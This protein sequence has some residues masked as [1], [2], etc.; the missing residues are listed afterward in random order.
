MAKYETS[1]KSRLVQE[2]LS[3]HAGYRALSARYGVS[4]TVLKS[5]VTRFKIHGEAGLSKK[6]EHYSAGFKESVLLRMHSSALSCTEVAALY[7]I[8]SGG[9]IV[10]IW[11]RLYHEGGL[12]ALHPKPRGRRPMTNPPK[13]TPSVAIAATEA[14]TIE[15]L[16]KENEYLRAEVAYLKKL[17]ELAQARQQAALKKRK[18]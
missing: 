2:Y 13:S 11:E 16:R 10:A 7:N 8:R 15:A 3:G 18:R 5:W 4:L 6:H 14:D 12:E 9:G 1:L 17:D